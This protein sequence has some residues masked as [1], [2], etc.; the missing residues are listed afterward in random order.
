M[1]D[2]KVAYGC[3]QKSM[4]SLSRNWEEGK[5]DKELLHRQV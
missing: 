4:E 2:Q 3:I 1:I 5:M